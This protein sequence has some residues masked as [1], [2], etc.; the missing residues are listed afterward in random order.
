MTTQAMPPPHSRASNGGK[1]KKRSASCPIHRKQLRQTFFCFR[2]V[3]SELVDLSLSRSGLMMK[4]DGVARI[5]SKN[6]STA[7]FWR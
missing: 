1:T 3:K 4:L 6:E 5:I 7:D 2:E